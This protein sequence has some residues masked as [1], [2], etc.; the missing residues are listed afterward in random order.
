LTK[1]YQVPFIITREI[2]NHL[3]EPPLYRVLDSVVPV[4]KSTELELLEIHHPLTSS[5]FEKLV[6]EYQAAFDQYR[7]GNFEA[8]AQ[9][10]LKLVAEYDDGPSRLLAKR[11]E[12]F[13][14]QSPQN[15]TGVYQWPSK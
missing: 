13:V 8:A 6:I 5:R 14:N 3:S 2:Y 11:C 9:A 1:Q 7:R 10:F 12:Q 4:G 15:W